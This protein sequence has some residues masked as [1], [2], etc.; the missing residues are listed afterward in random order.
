MNSVCAFENALPQMLL[1]SVAEMKFAG[2]ALLSVDSS[3]SRTMWRFE[4]KNNIATIMVYSKNLRNQSCEQ[5]LFNM[6]LRR[7]AGLTQIHIFQ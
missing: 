1:S 5:L 6:Q 7:K 3:A 4:S 2:V